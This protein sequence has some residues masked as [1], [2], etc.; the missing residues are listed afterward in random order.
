MSTE[1]RYGERLGAHVRGHTTEFATWAKARSCEVRLFDANAR[2]IDSHAMKSRGGGLFELTLEDV[3]HGALYKFVLDGKELPDPYARFLPKGVHGPAMVVEPRYEFR[4]PPC[5]GRALSEHVIYELHVGTF[6]PQGNY[7]GAIAKLPELAKLGVT[8]IELMPLASFAGNRGWGYDGVALFAPHPAYGTP[9]ELRELVDE[10]HAAG[11]S[12]FLDVVY[13]HFGPAGNYLSAFHPEYFTDKVRNAW[14]DSPNF[15]HPAVRAFVLANARYWLESFR[16]DG[17]R[18][19]ATHAIIDRSSKHVLRELVEMA[20]SLEPKRLLVAEDDRN[21]SKLLSELGLHG[22]WADDFHHQLR[23]TLTG[24]RDGYYRAYEPGVEGLAR[25][26]D[27]GWL[28]EGQVYPP[29]GKTRGTDASTVPAASLV[30]C[31]QNH[32]QVGNRALGERLSHQLDIDAYCLASTLLL[33]LPMTPLLFMGQE[34]AA[35]SPFLYFTDHEPELGALVT[36]GRAEEFKHFS[37]FAD[38]AKRAEIPDPQ[39]LETFERSRLR[40]DEREREPHARVL[41]LYHN[42]LALRRTDGVMRVNTREGLVADVPAPDLLRVRRY[43]GGEERVLYANFSREPIHFEDL[44]LPAE[45]TVLVTT[46]SDS[47]S[48]PPL[49]AAI[50]ATQAVGVSS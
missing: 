24:E 11:L 25:A 17:L 26:I 46:R 7:R 44:D 2:A 35:S 22:V 23:V 3:G 20:E 4:S 47:D 18:L 19:D 42:L 41:A 5:G 34:W 33:Y 6:T 37:A 32:D 14:G 50:F 40:W 12:V 39:A 9:D 45:Y 28:Y 21:E 43:A 38:P 10:A 29:S 15:A 30:Y 13:N 31:I 8:A 49:S 36:K 1:E 16:I 48:L 27:R